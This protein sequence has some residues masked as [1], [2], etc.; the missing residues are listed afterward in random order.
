M[1]VRSLMKHRITIER[2][3][4][5]VSRGVSKKT[6]T[7]LATDVPCRLFEKRG[8]LPVGQAGQSSEYDAVLYVATTT[9]INP[10]SDG[11]APDRVVV[12]GHPAHS[13]ATFGVLWAGDRSGEASHLTVLLRRRMSGE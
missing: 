3:T 2:A 13:G 10:K 8:K 12:T 9:D 6:W 1:S 11:D 4:V 5:T 7:E